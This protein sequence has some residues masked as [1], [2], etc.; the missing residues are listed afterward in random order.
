LFLNLQTNSNAQGINTVAVPGVPGSENILTNVST[1]KSRALNQDP[2]QRTRSISVSSLDADQVPI[3][4]AYEDDE[5]A[6][7]NNKLQRRALGLRKSNGEGGN[8]LTNCC[9]YLCCF[10][11]IYGC[12]QC[13]DG[14][15][16]QSRQYDKNSTSLISN[17]AELEQSKLV[18]TKTEP[19]GFWKILSRCTTNFKVALAII[20]VAV[21]VTI[22]IASNVTH[23]KTT[24]EDSQLFPRDSPSY[25]LLSQLEQYF[26]GMYLLTHSLSHL[27]MH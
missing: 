2:S 15:E 24:I 4:Q 13:K 14:D 19:P 8:V 3:D 17:R 20:I 16:S 23:I 7:I 26:P 25:Q 11:C 22:P 27:L 18:A 21:A 12:N 5:T 9:T 6:D 10:S 1:S